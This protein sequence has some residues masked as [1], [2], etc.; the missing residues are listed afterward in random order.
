[1]IEADRRLRLYEGKIRRD[2]KLARDEAI[3]RASEAK[4]HSD[5]RRNTED[6]GAVGDDH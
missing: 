5:T 2:K 6:V 4:Y 3:W 1:M